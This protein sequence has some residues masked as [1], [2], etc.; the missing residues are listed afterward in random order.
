MFRTFINKLLDNGL[1]F[2]TLFLHLLSASISTLIFLI[3]GVVVDW[4]QKHT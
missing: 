4:F 1:L 3:V 2:A